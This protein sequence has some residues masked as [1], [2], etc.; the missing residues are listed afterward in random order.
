MNSLR[1][2]V[3]DICSINAI[4]ALFEKHVSKEQLESYR[5][6]VKD[7]RARVVVGLS[8]GADSSVLALFAAAYLAPHYPNIDFLFT[9]TDA[10]PESCYETLDKIEAMTGIVIKRI[11][12]EKGLF[13]LIDEANGFLPSSQARWCT[14]Q[15]KTAPLLEYLRS[16]FSPVGVISLA[17]IRADEANREGITLAHSMENG[18]SA[19]PFV[20][21]GITKAMVFDI[22]DR[23]IGI[24]STYKYRSRSGCYSCFFQRN[25]E[26]IGMLINDSA[27]YQKT[28]AYEKLSE[29]DAK[30]WSNIPVSLTDAGIP[31]YYPVPAFVDIRKP[32]LVPEAM[33]TK[34]K[35]ANTSGDDL[36][37]LAPADNQEEGV[38][39]YAA[40]ALYVDGHLGMFGGREFTPGTYWQEFVTIS[41]SMAGLKSSLANYY[42][43]RKTTPMP[44]YSVDDLRIVIVQLRFPTGV[45]DT[46]KPSKDS[47]TWKSGTAYKQL[48]HLVKHCQVTLQRT[49]LERR[50]NDLQSIRDNACDSDV[51][52]AA[53][54]Q[55]AALA[56]Q[57][58]SSPAATGTVVWEGL[59]VPA[60]DI[61]KS[62]QLELSGISVTSRCKT[63]RENLE[64][65]EVP[66]ACLA[67]SI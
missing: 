10:E 59:Y 18:N 33:P 11:S 67:C 14:R 12:P 24:P 40:F 1:I 20:Q 4:K 66:M 28:E 39:L 52:Y 51:A 21:L 56:M 6:P 44:H 36:F 41:T 29:R 58:K 7:A 47:Y 23:T 2:P 25:A 49:D 38:D 43:F 55:L 63:P 9:D 46:L 15:L 27:A 34:T 31:A 61:Q 16:S 19:Y 65:D 8:G 32:E 42:R 5:L 13:E 30:R 60:P 54:E 64:F 53:D 50:Y 48:R 35:K 17:G 37:G 62:V 57:L 45:I 22:L 3:A 26:A